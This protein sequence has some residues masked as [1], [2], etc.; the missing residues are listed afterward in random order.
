MGVHDSV[1][2]FENTIISKVKKNPKL[3]VNSLNS[4]EYFGF[5]KLVN[6]LNNVLPEVRKQNLYNKYI[7]TL[8]IRSSKYKY[9]YSFQGL[10]VASI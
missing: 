4:H 6:F 5:I 10:V 7:F 8:C 3:K 2:Y 1:L 9:N